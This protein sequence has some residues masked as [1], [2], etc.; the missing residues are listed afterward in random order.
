MNNPTK[1]ILICEDHQIVIDGLR[2]I[3]LDFPRF[4]VVDTANNFSEL[5][6]SLKKHN[7]HILLL[8]LNLPHKNG[9]EILQELRLRKSQVKVLILTMYNKKTIVRKVFSEGANGFLLKNCS[10]EDLH[11]ALIHVSESDLFYYGEGVTKSKKQQGLDDDEF[12]K[13][14]QLTPREKE[15]IK[16]LCEGQ[17]VPDIARSMHISPLTVETHKKNIYRKLGVDTSVKLVRFVH[18]NQLL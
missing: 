4:D 10:S 17:K 3:I 15:I 2:S 8:D 12:Y 6:P 14:I 16:H 5:L 7:P 18:E 11:S 9:I 1:R 13:G